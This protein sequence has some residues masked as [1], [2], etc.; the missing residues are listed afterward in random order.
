M[1]TITFVS[2]YATGEKNDDVVFSC[3]Q[4]RFLP[5]KI[6]KQKEFRRFFTTLSKISLTDEKRLENLPERSVKKGMKIS[7]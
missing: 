4:P 5:T 2:F 1:N 6:K 7:Y 3:F